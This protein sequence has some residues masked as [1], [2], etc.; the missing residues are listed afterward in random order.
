LWALT[1]VVAAACTNHT[2]STTPHTGATGR[3]GNT[4]Q[5]W[6]AGNAEIGATTALGSVGSGTPT[7]ST[8]T[9]MTDR[10]TGTKPSRT[11]TPSR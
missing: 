7:D 6:E 2:D 5:T 4:F 10:N 9:A 11:S 3:P 1:I 8:G